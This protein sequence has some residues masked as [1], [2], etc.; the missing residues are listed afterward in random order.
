MLDRAFV[1]MVDGRGCLNRADYVPVL[2]TMGYHWLIAI[3][4]VMR[5]EVKKM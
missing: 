1:A 4:G 3:D 2:G 5:A